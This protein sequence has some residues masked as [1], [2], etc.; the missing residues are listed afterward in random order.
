MG[1]NEPPHRSDEVHVYEASCKR[2]RVFQYECPFHGA[3]RANP[4]EIGPDGKATVIP[5]TAVEGRHIG[6][7]NTVQG[8]VNVPGSLHRAP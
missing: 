1:S 6:R 5:T 2:L 7:I 3:T 8:Y 4:E